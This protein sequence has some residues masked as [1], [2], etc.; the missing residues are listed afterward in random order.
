M[1]RKFYFSFLA[2][3]LAL[4]ATVALVVGHSTRAAS[5]N[6]ALSALPASDFIISVDVQ[7]ALNEMLP[8]LLANNPQLL[9]KVNSSLKEFEETT[10]INP[11][12]FESVAVGG[13]LNSTNPPGRHDSNGV[14]ILRGSFKSDELIN[15]AFSAASKKCEFQKEEQQYE[16]K[17][18]YIIGP[19][20]PLKDSGKQSDT[21][22][23]EKYSAR[24]GVSP[25]GADK[26]AIAAVDANTI[27]VGSL[28]SVRASVDASL[29][30]NRVDD[31]LV[32]L[33]SQ[34]PNAVVSF[35]GRMPQSVSSKSG[36]GSDNPVAKYFASVRAFYGSFAVNSTE[37]ET[38]AAIRTE[39][40]QQASDIS[41]AINALKGVA[42]ISINQS[43]GKEMAAVADVL[44]SLSITA[45]DNEVHVDFKISLSNLAP[46]IRAH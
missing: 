19:I 40:A 35:S 11:H 31:E 17:T 41:Q 3:A 21:A 16:G 13:S 44:K 14:V 7:R 27:A 28:E 43:S 8:N 15:A 20:R 33:A 34:T 29:G 25:T 42:G 36:P 10:G 4:A 18:I 39:T 32:N 23:N 2:F 37:A 24:L 22:T 38:N 6:S 9:A 1:K 26:F 5:P 45:Q 12:V 30:R 46:F